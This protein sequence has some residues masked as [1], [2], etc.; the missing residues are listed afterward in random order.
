MRLLDYSV[1]MSKGFLIDLE[2]T[3]ISSGTPLTGSIEFIDY[4]NKN[5]IGYYLM[6]NTVSKTIE[7]WEIILHNNGFH[8][9]K[10]KIIYPIIVLNDYII[11]N[12][13]KSYYFIGPD[14]IKNLIRDSLDYD[15]PEHII[16]CDFESI[17]MNYEL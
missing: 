16:F 17:Q 4:L 12:N 1:Y 8:I 9:E 6:T 14:S 2:G 5:N 13:L 11:E 3:L 15:I 10:E 7:D